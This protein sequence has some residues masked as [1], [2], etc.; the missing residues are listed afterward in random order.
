MA[1]R[2]WKKKTL[3]KGNGKEID[4]KTRRN[5]TD[6]EKLDNRTK[7]DIKIVEGYIKILN[8]EV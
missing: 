3:S 2:K 8:N 4:Y 1:C 5:G 7:E 6:I